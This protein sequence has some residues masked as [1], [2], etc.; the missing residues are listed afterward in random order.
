MGARF[1]EYCQ[2]ARAAKELDAEA[3][4]RGAALREGVQAARCALL[5]WM[6]GEGVD[7]AALPGG[8]A[9]KRRVH[10]NR[11]VVNPAALTEA[12]VE[13]RAAARDIIAREG[14]APREAYVACFLARFGAA[15]KCAAY[16]DV[17]EAG[18]KA[19]RGRHAVEPRDL[20]EYRGPVPPWVAELAGALEASKRELAEFA[21][22]RR[23]AAAVPRS[24]LRAIEAEV[25]GS[26]AVMPGHRVVLRLPEGGPSVT[27]SSRVSRAKPPIGVQALKSELAPRIADQLMALEG[28]G[29]D[30][31]R[32]RVSAVMEEVVA[33]YLAVKME[34]RQPELRVVLARAGRKRSAAELGWGPADQGDGGGEAAA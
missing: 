16:A 6:D 10:S 5:Q 30:V 27:L 33:K 2:L 22:A 20:V 15:K 11:P 25:R 19:D 17:V 9:L 12:W 26:L 14:F 7:R 34:G 31:S 13:A 23:E 24:R 1:E 28:A 8:R 29:G 3:K 32:D 18:S 21:L 4:A